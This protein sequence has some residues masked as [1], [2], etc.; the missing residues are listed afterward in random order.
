M[1]T[2][3]S[4]QMLTRQDCTPPR[5]TEH[6]TCGPACYDGRSPLFMLCA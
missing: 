4:E 2:L 1:Q 6:W 3:D 5:T